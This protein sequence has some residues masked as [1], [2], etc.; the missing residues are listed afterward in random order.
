MRVDMRASLLAAIFG[1]GMAA[2]PAGA[3]K[4]SIG[5]AA[6]VTS[7]DPHYHNLTPNQSLAS[8]IFNRLVDMDAT[9]HPVAS[10]AESWKLIDDH[11]WEFRLR[12]A[13]FHDGSD[14]TAED[15]AFTLNRVPLVPNSPASYSI[16]TKAVTGVEIVGPHTIRL[17]TAGPYPLLP[18]DLTQVAIISHGIGADPK[19]GDFNSGRNA[20]GT[21]PLNSSPTV[22]ATASNWRA[23]M[24]IGGRSQPGRRSI[25]GSSATMPR[26]PRRCCRAM[27]T[28]STRC[29]PAIWRSCA[30]TRS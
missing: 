15:V 5:V 22:P 7:I 3:Q 4:L 1:L 17:R 14:F 30:P 11:T 9:A 28:S 13:K 25:T 12:S 18:I 10:L 29:R 19:T 27:S 6:P 20:I 26:A 16:Y 21:G 2:G 8:N 24:P 23:T